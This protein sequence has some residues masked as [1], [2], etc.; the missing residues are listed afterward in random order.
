MLYI[1]EILESITYIT[2]GFVS[3][4]ALLEASY[5]MRKKIGIRKGVG[6]I[7]PPPKSILPM[8]FRDIG[9]KERHTYGNSILEKILL[10]QQIHS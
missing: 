1:M 7:L 4:L 2:L 8:A 10:N 3:T 5:R 6:N 9:R